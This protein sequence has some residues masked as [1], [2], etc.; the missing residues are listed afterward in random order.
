MSSSAKKWAFL[1]MYVVG[2]DDVVNFPHFHLI[3]NHWV[4]FNLTWHKASFFFKREII[5][6]SENLLIFF[7]HRS[8]QKP[9]DQI[10]WNY[11]EA[12]SG[13]VVSSLSKSWSRRVEWATI[14]IYKNLQKCSLKTFGK[15]ITNLCGWILRWCRFKFVQIMILGGRLEPQYG[16]V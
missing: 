11:V 6:I 10:S 1:V 14:V 3:Q 8:S 9:F 12:S 16:C 15:I 2:V 13:K 5:S 7:K 4:N